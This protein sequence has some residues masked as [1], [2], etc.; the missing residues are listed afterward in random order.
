MKQ[1]QHK[2]FDRLVLNV[3]VLQ[4]PYEG[5]HRKVS[6]QNYLPVKGITIDTHVVP[7]LNPLKTLKNIP[8]RTV[9]DFTTVGLLGYT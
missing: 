8:F 5:W 7:S 9:N 2:E 3:S 6:W 1:S 4:L